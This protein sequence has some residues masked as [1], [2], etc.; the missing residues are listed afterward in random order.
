MAVKKTLLLLSFSMRIL[1][2][3]AEPA[4]D[5]CGKNAEMEMSIWPIFFA[6][7]LSLLDFSPAI[8][9][10]GVA[11]RNQKAQSTKCDFIHL[12]LSGRE[13]GKIQTIYLPCTLEGR[14]FV[15]KS[16]GLLC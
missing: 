4:T 11:A 7:V 12:F 5:S 10:K 1:N 15:S 13:Q 2:F 8:P 9:Q 16:D 3:T 14:C 6:T